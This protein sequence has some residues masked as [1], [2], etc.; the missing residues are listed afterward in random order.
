MRGWRSEVEPEVWR[1]TE[2]AGSGGG[3]RDRA[4]NEQIRLCG[5]TK[6]R[7]GV[8]VLGCREG[9]GGGG[10][11]AL[12]V[13]RGGLPDW[14]EAAGRGV[15]YDWSKGAENHNPATAKSYI[16]LHSPQ[17]FGLLSKSRA[18]IC[19]QEAEVKGKPRVGTTQRK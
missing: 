12:V 18:H 11:G 15:S 1:T 19:V 6:G 17:P 4:G 10:H 3:R 7:E 8:S 2:A 14:A 16:Y 9:D 5:S 13:A